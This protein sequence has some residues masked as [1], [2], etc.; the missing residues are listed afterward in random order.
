MPSSEPADPL[1][2]PAGVPPLPEGP[3]S[4]SRLLALESEPLR[5]LLSVGLR[6]GLEEPELDHH[7]QTAA[8]GLDLTPTALRAL[9]EERGWVRWDP[10]RQRW[11]T[12][13]GGGGSMGTPQT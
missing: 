1:R 9:L 7:C 8:T 4:M 10:V 13:L 12:R 5:R 6:A 3:L 2:G 11:R